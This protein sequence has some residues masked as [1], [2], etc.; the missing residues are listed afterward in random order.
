MQMQQMQLLHPQN[1]AFQQQQQWDKLRRRQVATPRGSMVFMDKDQPM[2][3]VKLEN[4]TESPIE[5][6]FSTLNKQQQLQLR[7]QI[8][9]SNQHAQSGQ[10]FKQMS[11]VQLP[12]LQAQYNYNDA[13]S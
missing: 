5:S 12:Q 1:L 10:Q 9:M 3:D 2:V 13:F 8:S 4:M 7:Q 6:M 11:N